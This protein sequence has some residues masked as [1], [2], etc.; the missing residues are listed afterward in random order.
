MSTNLKSTSDVWY[1]AFLMSKG[2]KII[3]YTVIARGKVRCDFDI[4]EEDW[5]KLKIEFN[6]SDIVKFKHYIDMIKDMAFIG[7]L[8][9]PLLSVFEVI[10]KNL[11]L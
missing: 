9:L 8:T 6:N 5:K 7:L 1:A 10:N 4:T 11:I 3:N 2:Y